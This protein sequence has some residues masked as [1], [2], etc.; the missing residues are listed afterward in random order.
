[1]VKKIIPIE[2]TKKY[3]GK[4]WEQCNCMEL[5]RRVYIDLGVQ[6]PED[7]KGIRTANIPE[8]IKTQP[9]FAQAMLVSACNMIGKRINKKEIQRY[10]LVLLWQNFS[11]ILYPGIYLGNGKI[12]TSA[13]QQGVQVINNALI[14]RIVAAWRVC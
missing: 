12:M 8:L 11:R 3:L 10:D 4:S 14:N 9:R 1:M 5:V 13:I 2:L 7:H 6:L